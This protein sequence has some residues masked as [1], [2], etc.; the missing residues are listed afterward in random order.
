MSAGHGLV[1]PVT[2]EMQDIGSTDVAERVP[3]ILITPSRSRRTVLTLTTPSDAAFAMTRILGRV[4]MATTSRHI[5]HA[6]SWTR[7]YGKGQ[8]T[9]DSAQ[10]ANAN[11]VSDPS[12]RPLQSSDRVRS[13]PSGRQRRRVRP[14]I[15]ALRVVNQERAD[16]EES[17][18]DA[19]SEDEAIVGIPGTE[20]D[21][22]SEDKS[23]VEALEELEAESGV[24]LE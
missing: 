6:E 1:S 18:V 12:S 7:N 23:D 13:R 16:A 24:G 19:D 15:G 11:D 9:R 8:T 2:R 14:R 20:A 5:Y 3:P 22:D 21:S 17:D 4:P 10:H